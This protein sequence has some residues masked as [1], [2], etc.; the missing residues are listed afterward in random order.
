MCP[1]CSETSDSPPYSDPPEESTVDDTAAPWRA[2]ETTDPAADTSEVARLRRMLVVAGL[3]I[4]AIL[5]VA[6]FLLAATGGGAGGVTVAG[7]QLPESPGDSVR[8]GPSASPLLVVEVVGAVRDPGVYRLAVGSRV[9][10]AVAAAG[11]YAARLDAARA[12]RELNLAAR[13][14]DGDQVRVPSRDDAPGA[15][16]AGSQAASAGGIVHLSSATAAELDALPGVG[17]VTAAKILASRDKQPFAA[18][19]DL[20]TRK[21]VGASTFEK[22]RALVAVP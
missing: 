22:L 6:G 14:N 12:A 17:P 11:G 20:R 10:D 4:A 1:R 13:L 7:A 16:A 15:A 2:L 19:D 3:A 5:G 18:I 9:G 8:A 21:L